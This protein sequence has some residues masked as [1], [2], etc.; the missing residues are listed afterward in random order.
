MSVKKVAHFTNIAPH[1]R[2]ALW[3]K[4]LSDESHQYHFFFGRKSASGIK[5]I[6]FDK[7]KWRS[8]KT[9]LHH[10]KNLRLLGRLIF[11]IGVLNRVL[12]KELDAVILLGD[13]NVF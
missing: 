13:M 3:Y 8:I 4:I 7:K 9:R 1:Y 12:F 6:D 10:L 5:S 11:Q 2:E